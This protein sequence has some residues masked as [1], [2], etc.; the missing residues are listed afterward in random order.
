MAPFSMDW[1]F[2]DVAADGKAIIKKG[3]MAYKPFWNYYF[4]CPC[5]ELTKYCIESELD[6]LPTRY[7]YKVDGGQ[8]GLSNYKG[9]QG[10]EL[11][12]VARSNVI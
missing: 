2:L 9:N 4:P 1:S 10:S 6:T 11:C 8:S 12:I 5:G 3:F 7:R